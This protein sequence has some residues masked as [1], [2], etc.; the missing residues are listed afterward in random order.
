[1]AIMSELRESWV[2]IERRYRAG[3]I[4]AA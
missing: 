3:D 2:E 1:M 4:N